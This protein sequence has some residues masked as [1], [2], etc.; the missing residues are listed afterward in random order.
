MCSSVEASPWECTAFA[1]W[2]SISPLHWLSESLK[3][4][5]ISIE[6]DTTLRA[7]DMILLLYL[8]SIKKICGVKVVWHNSPCFCKWLFE[9]LCQCTEC[10]HLIFIF[11]LIFHWRAISYPANTEHWD[12]SDQGWSWIL[13]QSNGNFWKCFSAYF[14]NLVWSYQFSS[15]QPLFYGHYLLMSADEC[16][17][18]VI[19]R[20][21]LWSESTNLPREISSKSPQNQYSVHV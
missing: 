13:H 2:V 20:S 10:F 14:P 4:N 11:D 15:L 8:H 17:V 16:V 1:I 6:P 7:K 3:L 5:M 21:I 18:G 9:F 19:L 12:T